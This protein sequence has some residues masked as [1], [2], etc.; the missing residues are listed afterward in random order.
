VRFQFIDRESKEL[1]GD[2]LRYGFLAQDI[3]QI[4]GEPRVIVDDT[5]PDNLKITDSMLIPVLVRAVQELTDRVNELSQE[6]DRLKG[7]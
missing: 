1:Q 6:V 3:Q 7:V 2:R 4:E 5:D